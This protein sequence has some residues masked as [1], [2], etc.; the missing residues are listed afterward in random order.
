[1]N[2]DTDLEELSHLSKGPQ[3]KICDSE[4]TE[5]ASL[6]CSAAC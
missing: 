1:M 3:L 2:E 4:V 6:L 5:S